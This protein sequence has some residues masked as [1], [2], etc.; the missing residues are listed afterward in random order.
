M[1]KEKNGR[2]EEEVGEGEQAFQKMSFWYTVEAE[3]KLTN[4][5]ML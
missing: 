1:E 5:R 2:E 3:F 4:Y